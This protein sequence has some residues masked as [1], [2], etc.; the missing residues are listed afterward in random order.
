MVVK[1]NCACRSIG[2][3]Q[4]KNNNKIRLLFS[5]QCDVLFFEPVFMLLDQEQVL[6][7]TNRWN[8]ILEKKTYISYEE[9]R[10]NLHAR[11]AYVTADEEH[12]WPFETEMD[13]IRRSSTPRK[14]QQNTGI[15]SSS[16][17]HTIRSL[18]SLPL[19]NICVRLQFALT[20]QEIKQFGAR[21]NKL[22]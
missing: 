10:L 17:E 15:Q 21:L 9:N 5:K 19:R 2:V 13:A 16:P 22:Y 18:S 11:Y 1:Y 6:C 4:K 8:F 20:T 14:L 3:Q 12:S 7:K